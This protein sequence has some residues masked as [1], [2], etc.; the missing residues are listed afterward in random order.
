LGFNV[1]TFVRTGTLSNGLREDE[2][3]DCDGFTDSTAGY[4]AAGWA[5]STDSAWTFTN[6]VACNDLAP[7]YC[8][9]QPAE[10]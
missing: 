7:H 1:D 8:V 2:T 9:E 3:G 5:M 6:M 10:P 4:S